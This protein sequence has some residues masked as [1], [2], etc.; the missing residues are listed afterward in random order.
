[1]NYAPELGPFQLIRYLGKSAIM[2]FSNNSLQNN[3]SLSFEQL[4]LNFEAHKDTRRVAF[5]LRVLGAIT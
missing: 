2:K 5:F 3:G 4:F 1:M